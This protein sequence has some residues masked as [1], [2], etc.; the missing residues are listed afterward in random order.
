[1]LEPKPMA[2]LSS[3]LLARK[4]DARPAVRRSFI[5][6]TSITPLPVAVQKAD[7]LEN[8][9]WNVGARLVPVPA[10]ASI[11]LVVKQLQERIASN[12]CTRE[13]EANGQPV[14]TRKPRVAF[15]LR[16]EPERHLRLRLA[17]MADGRSGQQILTQALDEFLAKQPG[18]EAMLADVRQS[19]PDQ[20]KV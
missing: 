17:K 9:D 3:G 1:M 19:V 4:G 6:L 14:A 15:T 10:P 18:L 7:A 20:D 8:V 11:S 16:I 5:A 13:H 2:S 12:L